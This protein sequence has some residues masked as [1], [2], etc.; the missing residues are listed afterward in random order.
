MNDYGPTSKDGG[1]DEDE[2]TKLIK[3]LPSFKN[4]ATRGRGLSQDTRSNQNNSNAKDKENEGDMNAIQ[5]K[6]RVISNQ[7][8][9]IFTGAQIPGQSADLSQAH[10]PKIGG[11][12][13]KKKDPN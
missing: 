2:H 9:K 8:R 7:G 3:S 4:S 12:P 1:A 10:V 11:R 13:M 6:K 5:K